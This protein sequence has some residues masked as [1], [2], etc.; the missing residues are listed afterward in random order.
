MLENDFV[1]KA[2]RFDTVENKWEKIAN[3]RQKRGYAFGVATEGKIFVAGGREN[4]ESCLKTC[5]MFNISTNEWQLIGSLTVHRVCGSMM[6]LKGTLYVLGGLDDK[7]RS[8]L[9]VECYDPTEDK[10]IKKTTIPVK[11]ISRG[12]NERFTGCVLKLSKGVLDKNVI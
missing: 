3:M 6:C 12:H 4:W 5:E 9:C 1:T 10:W 11:M 7:Y 8:Q 2:E